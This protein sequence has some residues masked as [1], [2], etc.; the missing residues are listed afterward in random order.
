MAHTP[1]CIGNVTRD[2]YF[3][4]A[5]IDQ[6]D[7]ILGLLFLRNNRVHLDFS[8]DILKIKGHLVPNSI[9]AEKRAVPNAQGRVGCPCTAA[10]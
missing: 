5:S 9:E 1:M 4:I 10:H 2:T 7:C 8:E 3:N 6:Y